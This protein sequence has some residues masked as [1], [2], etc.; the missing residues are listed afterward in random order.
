ML[1]PLLTREPLAADVLL[2]Q[3]ILLGELAQPEEAL[4]VLDHARASLRPQERLLAPEDP[5]GTIELHRAYTLVAL[6][7]R[8]AA[9]A[10]LCAVQH[11]AP[12][13][14][15]AAATDPV[16]AELLGP[17]SAPSG[18]AELRRIA[19]QGLL[20]PDFGA[21]AEIESAAQ[22]ADEAATAAVT[23]E[24]LRGQIAERLEVVE[25]EVGAD[26]DLGGQR[27]LRRL[28]S[29]RHR[30]GRGHRTRSRGRRR[31]PR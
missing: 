1:T 22:S 12:E 18:Y 23:K 3:G 5:L 28:A 24:A 11:L 2:A 19:Q 25:V 30:P 13:R 14:A 26:V 7:D 16:L 29:R 15:A 10:A 8:V 4:A 6:G 9:A 31:P 20:H 21:D 17:P 27:R